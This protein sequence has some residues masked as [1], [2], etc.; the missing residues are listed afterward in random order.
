V[1]HPNRT[2]RQAILAWNRVTGGLAERPLR[3]L[4]IPNHRQERV[5]L[6][7]TAFPLSFQQD[8]AGYLA[9]LI[10]DDLFGERGARTVSPDTL[11][12]RGSQLLV[13]ASALVQSGRD[14]QSIRSLADLLA[15]EL[16]RP[17]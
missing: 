14:P 15:P 17:R 8:V 9:S 1:D 5:A 13:L 4:Q 2:V 10:G 6:L 16:Q 7:P 11:K 3:K 12:T